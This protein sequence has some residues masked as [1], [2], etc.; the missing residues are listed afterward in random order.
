MSRPVHF[1]DAGT[2]GAVVDPSRAVA[3]CLAC[4]LTAVTRVSV[5]DVEEH[6]RA[7]A[8]R[9]ARAWLRDELAALGCPHAR[10]AP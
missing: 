1:L 9:L 7:E 8:Y 6:G 5:Y 3:G 4:G 2:P 10:G